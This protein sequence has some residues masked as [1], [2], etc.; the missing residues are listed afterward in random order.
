MVPSASYRHL[1]APR[2]LSCYLGPLAPY[3]SMVL[4]YI[5]RQSE[6]ILQV[7]QLVYFYLYDNLVLLGPPWR[8]VNRRVDC[9][10]PPLAADITRAARKVFRNRGPLFVAIASNNL[11]KL[12]ILL[13][14]HINYFDKTDDLVISSFLKFNY[15]S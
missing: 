1:S 8:V 6:I 14:Q 7:S 10:S 11:D 3:S 9:T 12:S 15:L 5:A 4:Q 2:Q 13:K